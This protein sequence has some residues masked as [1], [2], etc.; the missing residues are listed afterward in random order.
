MYLTGIGG[1]GFLLVRSSNGSYEYVDF[2]E[3]APAAAFQD[4]Y[5]TNITA[6][7]LGGLAR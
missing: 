7:L 5:N 4:M 3:A 6:S 2:R 1:G